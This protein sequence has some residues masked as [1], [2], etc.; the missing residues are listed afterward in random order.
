[1][2][3]RHVSLGLLVTSVLCSGC[4]AIAPVKSS[5]AAL[6]KPPKTANTAASATATTQSSVK[7]IEEIANE[8][9]RSKG[10][11]S[12]EQIDALIRANAKCKP[13]DPRYSN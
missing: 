12:R 1:M 9:M 8:A 13:N 3:K 6:N 5:L 7:S 4:N 2:I 10:K 11:L